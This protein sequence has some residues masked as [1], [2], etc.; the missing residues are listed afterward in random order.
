MKTY[1]IILIIIGLILLDIITGYIFYKLR[2]YRLKKKGKLVTERNRGNIL[3]FYLCCYTPIFLC[4]CGQ[5]GTMYEACCD[6]DNSYQTI[7]QAEITKELPPGSQRR[8]FEQK[9]EM[10]TTEEAKKRIS[11]LKI[12]E[13]YVSINWISSVTLLPI[14]TIYELISLD[15][16][17]IL[18]DDKVIR[19]KLL[20]GVCF[21]CGT[22][23]ST[24]NNFCPNCGVELI[25]K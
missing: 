5:N 1:Q 18:K 16:T 7:P 22:S 20:E 8:E 11:D 3:F 2:V 25:K 24:Y 21:E 10:F 19:K 13:N 9:K 14:E 15:E 6:R 23:Y 12:D 4:S 17:Y